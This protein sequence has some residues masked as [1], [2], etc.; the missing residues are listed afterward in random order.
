MD[1]LVTELETLES[2]VDVL[3][4]CAGL[5]RGWLDEGK[6]YDNQHNDPEA[7]EKLLW[8]GLDDNELSM[9]NAVNIG[10]VYF[11]STRM[12]PLL[13]KGRDPTVIVIASIT[14]LMLQR[15][16]SIFRHSVS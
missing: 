5:N 3:V 6:K 11:M 8:N 16:A 14:G 9:T 2:H 13:R 15:Y 1:K 4:N 12:V 7:V 10:G